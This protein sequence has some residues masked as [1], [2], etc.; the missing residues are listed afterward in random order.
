MVQGLVMDGMR[1]VSGKGKAKVSDF[2]GLATIL[3]GAVE[4][5]LVNTY[6]VFG[7]KRVCCFL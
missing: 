5:R 1:N 3:G 2:F 7:L 4:S 6:Q